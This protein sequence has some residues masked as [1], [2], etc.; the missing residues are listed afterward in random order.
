MAI[1]DKRKGKRG[2][3]VSKCVYKEKGLIIEEKKEVYEESELGGE[4]DFHS[5][6]NH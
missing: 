4:G 2:K 1:V 6:L 5:G 3:K